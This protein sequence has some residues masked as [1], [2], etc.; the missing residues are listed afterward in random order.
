MR[1]KSAIRRVFRRFGYDIHRIAAAKAVWI[2]VGAHTGERSFQAAQHN[3]SL[4]VFAFEP[5]WQLARELMGKLANF[6]ILPI[7]VSDADGMSDFFLNS[8]DA[9]SS[10][11]GFE[12]GALQSW[13][14]IATLKTDSR[15][16]VPTMR[17]DTFMT[18]MRLA[19]VDFLK[20]DTQGA[21]FAVLKSAGECIRKIR[22]ITLEV[23]ISAV[24]L[25][26]GSAGKQEIVQYLCERGFTL[27]A[28]ERNSNGREEN[29]T[30]TAR[31]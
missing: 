10:L 16:R 26:R 5:N 11:L 31:S 19:Q 28:V 6:V 7:A 17:L 9:T 2:D 20:I 21:D 25:Y 4:L 24:R 12:P 3:P 8:E 15:I 18:S 22:R 30:F 23:D 29:L 13:E 27:T 14:G 1:V